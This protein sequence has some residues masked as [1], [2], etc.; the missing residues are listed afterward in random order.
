MVLLVVTVDSDTVVLSLA[1]AVEDVL[2]DSLMILLV[3]TVDDDALVLSVLA[4]E[5]GV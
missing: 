4:R 1:A 5:I 2:L 3:V